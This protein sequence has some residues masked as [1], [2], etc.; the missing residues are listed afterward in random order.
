MGKLNEAIR[1]NARAQACL[2]RAA[3]AMTE[4]WT[5][6]NKAHAIVE[7]AHA[8]YLMAKADELTQEHE[9][10]CDRALEIIKARTAS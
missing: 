8:L 10:R 1:L 7:T 5:G 3:A 6:D 9:G 2:A 4:P